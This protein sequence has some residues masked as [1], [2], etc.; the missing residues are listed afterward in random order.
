MKEI[1]NGKETRRVPPRC[2]QHGADQWADQTPACFGPG[3]VVST[4]NKWVQQHQHE[5][6]MSGP[7]E[8]VEKENTRLRKENRLLR[9]ER[10]ILKKATI[11]FAG[12][13]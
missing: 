10:E 1:T 13:N 5:D 6:L 11:F 8:D 7:H 3:V 9:E 12:Q 4:L 2:G